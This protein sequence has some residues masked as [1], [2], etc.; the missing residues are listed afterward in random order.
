M[1][2]MPL[3]RTLDRRSVLRA[4]AALPLAGLAACGDGGAPRPTPSARTTSS[5]SPTTAAPTGSPSAPGAATQ[6]PPVPRVAQ[7]LVTGLD[8]PWGI[9]FLPGADA[10]TALVGCRDSF[11]VL[12]IGEGRTTR[13]GTVPGT[14][15]TVHAGGEGGLLGI[16]LHPDYPAQPWL[17]AYHTTDTGNRVVRMRCDGHSL[18]RPEEILG[19][20]RT[21]LHH[22]GGGLRFGADGNLF[23]STGDAERRDDAQDRTSLNGKILRIT[24]SGGVPADNPFGNEVWSYGH[25]N[26][27]GLALDQ[28]GRLWASEF[29][30]K[31]ADELNLIVKGADYGW[32]EVEGRDGPGGFRDPLAQWPTDDASPSGLTIARGR[33]WLGALRGECVWE[34]DLSSGRTRRHLAGHGRLRLV[35]AAPDG[36][37]WVGTSNRDGRATPRTGDDRLLRVT[38]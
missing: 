1:E 32:P 17:Y 28:R 21:S 24:P 13:I 38:L 5:P 20:I 26:V 18:G 35:A 19:G 9:A 8:V 30:D 31:G 22:N 12:R 27:E 2:N 34:V 29:G 36:S 4:A 14:V 23:V 37:L 33:A 16:A 15:T 25:R 7:T 6:G 3:D 10:G 11:E